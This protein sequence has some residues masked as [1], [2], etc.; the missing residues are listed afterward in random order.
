MSRRGLLE[1]FRPAAPPGAAGRVGVPQDATEDTALL[2]VLASLAP[3]L[4]EAERIRADARDRRRA[5]REDAVVRASAIAARARVEAAEQRA[6]EAARVH[7]AGE[8]EGRRLADQAARE[9]DAIRAEGRRRTPDL[10]AEVVATVRA[11]AER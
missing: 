5:L 6:V 8:R 4:A 3:T 11:E 10:V 9:A 7:V 2:A 1:R